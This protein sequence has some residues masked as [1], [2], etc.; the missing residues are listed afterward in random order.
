MALATAVSDV[1]KQVEAIVAAKEKKESVASFATPLQQAVSR[2]N[3][4]QTAVQQAGK[5]GGCNSDAVFQV[6]EQANALLR[7]IVTPERCGAGAGSAHR[8]RFDRIAAHEKRAAAIMAIMSSTVS[9]EVKV[10]SMKTTGMTPSEIALKFSQLPTKPRPTDLIVWLQSAGFDCRECIDGM[11]ITFLFGKSVE[12]VAQLL[13]AVQGRTSW[14]KAEAIRGLAVVEKDPAKI[15][16][17]LTTVG[18]P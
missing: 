16:A 9:D 11:R 5:E 14:D 13:K 2:M 6:R 3:V 7:E 15:T 10:S 12:E 18:Y 8:T 17:A 1:Q 4:A